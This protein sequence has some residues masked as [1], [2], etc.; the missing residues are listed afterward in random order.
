MLGMPKKEVKKM[1]GNMEDYLKTIYELG[2]DKNQITNKAIAKALNISAPS[3]SEMLKKLLEE[4]YVEYES[5]RGVKLT[6]NGLEKARKVKRKHLLWEVFLVE[7]L[8][9]D[10]DEVHEEAEKLEHVTSEKLEERL[11]KFLNY[12]KTCPHGND[13]IE[14]GQDDLEYKL[15]EDLTSNTKA[16]IKRLTDKRE[17]LNYVSGLGLNIGDIIEVIELKKDG[18]MVIVKDGKIMAIEK[19]YTNKIY[20]E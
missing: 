9:Y 16:I 12:P 10:W 7:K 11:D 18:T 1:T 15:L 14:S 5:Y 8:G 20:V 4:G 6:K 13:I 17:L 3:V 19:E 2:G